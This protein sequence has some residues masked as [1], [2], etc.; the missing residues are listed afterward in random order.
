M[1]TLFT[2]IIKQEIPSYKIYEDDYTYAFLDINPIY[3][4]HTLIAP[5][6]EVDKRYDLPSETINQL[7]STAK[8]LSP[9][10]EKACDAIRVALIIE[11]IEI[12]HAHI[13]LIPLKQWETLDGSKKMKISTK[14]LQKTQ[15][16]IN[17]FK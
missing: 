10:I 15:N 6:I 13:H 5:K 3:A 17:N 1:A 4:W 11:W 16:R 14:E 8:R 7:M 2:R 12:P 9:V